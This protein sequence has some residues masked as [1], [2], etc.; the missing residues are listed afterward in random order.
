MKLSARARYAV[1]LMVELDRLDGRRKPVQ[2]SRIAEITG[3]S[4]RYLEQ[5]AIALK[6]HSLLRG[7][8]G[9]NGGYLLAKPPSNI[10]IGDVLTA[11]IGPIHFSV[12]VVEPDICMRADFC[13]CRLIWTLLDRRVNSLLEEYTVADLTDQDRLEGI[14]RELKGCLPDDGVEDAREGAQHE[15]GDL[16]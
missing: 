13:E 5:L 12:C 7:I 4:R 3:I 6:S 11:V 9:R 15:A 1:R 16:S 10:T 14:R 8:S 2:L